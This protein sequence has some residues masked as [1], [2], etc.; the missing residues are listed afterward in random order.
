[1]QVRGGRVRGMEL[2]LR[3]LDSA[4]RELFG[5]G[6][7]GDRVRGLV[8]HALGSDKDAAVRVTVF[9]PSTVMVVVRAPA[10][11]ETAPRRLRSVAYQRPA[12]HLKHVGSFGQIYY[13]RLAEREGF[14]DA[15]LVGPDGVISESTIANL[16]LF[17][18][19]G[20]V[21]WPDAPALTGITMQLLMPLLPSRRASVLLGDLP[22]YEGAFLANSRGVVAVGRV[23]DVELPVPEERMKAVALAYES[24]PWDAI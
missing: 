10:D 9:Q 20:D 15:L 12:A 22:R 16:G 1:M 13:G 4:N 5:A 6:L 23:D 19:D 17:S 18:G 8:R 24:V 21:V 14:D 3:R 11:P 2:H 7:A